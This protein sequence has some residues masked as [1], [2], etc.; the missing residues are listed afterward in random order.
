[1]S[2]GKVR[3]L[4]SLLNQWDPIGVYDGKL[5]CPPDEYDC[6]LGPLL[7]RLSHGNGRAELDEFLRREMND[8]FGLDPVSCRTDVFADQLLTWWATKAAPHRGDTT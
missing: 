7:T 6:L 4:R 1:M 2:A 8:H 5:N 3:E